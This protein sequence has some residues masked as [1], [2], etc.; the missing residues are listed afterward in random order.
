MYQDTFNLNGKIYSS[1][2]NLLLSIIN[3]LQQVINNTHDNLI[4]KRIGDIIIKMNF[5][6]N[7]NKKNY[8]SIMQQFSLMQ[9]QFS[10]MQQQLSQINQNVKNININIIN[11]QELNDKET[12]EN[13]EGFYIDDIIYDI[14]DGKGIM[15]YNNGDRYEGDFRNDKKDG[16]G[17][18]YYNN[19]DRS[20]GVI[21][22][23]INQ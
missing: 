23:M 14:R 7:E 20:M 22:I 2:N 4:I 10:L 8:Q 5:A 17:I 19:G 6:I 1:N 3:D 12:L 16:K 18:Y 21:I 11:N 15:Y 9:Q 13:E